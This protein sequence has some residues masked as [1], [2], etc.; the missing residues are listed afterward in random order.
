V[1]GLRVEAEEEDLLDFLRIE[2]GEGAAATVDMVVGKTMGSGL[3]EERGRKEEEE[4]ERASKSAGQ[5][6][7]GLRLAGKGSRAFFHR[8]RMFVGLMRRFILHK[9]DFLVKVPVKSNVEAR[10]V[11]SLSL[12]PL[13]FDF[14][15]SFSF[16]TATTSFPS[17]SSRLLFSSL[18]TPSPPS[19]SSTL[20]LAKGSQPSLLRGLLGRPSLSLPSLLP[21]ECY[22]FPAELVIEVR[23]L[24]L[25]SVYNR[26][27]HFPPPCVYR[28]GGRSPL[29]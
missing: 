9:E 21:F 4:E 1:G 19:L 12:L 3:G 23:T 13:S 6:G 20:S 10:E 7:R 22:L 2:T 8:H 27:N 24:L 26:A 25:P 16:L 28:Y 17:S 5:R 14:V 18:Y 11:A 15:R 29:L